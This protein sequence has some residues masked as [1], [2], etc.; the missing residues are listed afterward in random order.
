MHTYLYA[1]MFTALGNKRKYEQANISLLQAARISSFNR[2]YLDIL[3]A[4][5]GKRDTYIISHHLGSY[6]ISRKS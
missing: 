2:Y 6:R 5:Q 4:E 1:K 3:H